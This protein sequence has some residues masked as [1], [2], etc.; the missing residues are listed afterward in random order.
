[1]LYEYDMDNIIKII[2]I[3]FSNFSNNRINQLMKNLNSEVNIEIKKFFKES[4]QI[5]LEET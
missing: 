1:M 5:F 3:L 2:V 4:K